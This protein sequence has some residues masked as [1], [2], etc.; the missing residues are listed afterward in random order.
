MH[1]YNKGKQDLQS[2]SASPAQPKVEGFPGPE[3]LQI[4]SNNLNELE[5]QQMEERRFKLAYADQS[6]IQALEKELSKPENIA[7]IY[8]EDGEKKD[9]DGLA[10]SESNPIQAAEKE[11]L[12]NGKVNEVVPEKKAEV[13]DKSNDFKTI[14]A[15]AKAD[16]EKS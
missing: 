11:L 14:A 8:K 12:K 16:L 1:A 5:T 10:Y 7:Q 13:K 15:E 2:I 4:S 6:P 3:I 9:E